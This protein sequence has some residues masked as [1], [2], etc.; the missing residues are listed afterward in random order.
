MTPSER[1]GE[2]LDRAVDLAALEGMRAITI[3]RV[4]RE[5]GVTAGLISHYFGTLD[6]LLSTVFRLVS[7]TINDDLP[8]EEDSDDP[9]SQLAKQ[10]YAYVEPSNRTTSRI[11]LE[12]VY[13]SAS[14][15]TLKEAVTDEM[16]RDH[17][18]LTLRIQRVIDQRGRSSRSASTIATSLLSLIDGRLIQLWLDEEAVGSELVDI[19]FEYAESALDLQAGEMRNRIGSAPAMGQ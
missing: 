3:K 6:E 12:A 5:L 17:E 2:I 9:V 7:S 10:L 18:S 4:A 11:W 16:W 13:L 15:P 8:I 19:L 1:R 14:L